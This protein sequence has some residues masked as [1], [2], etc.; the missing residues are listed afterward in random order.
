M[1]AGCVHET[2]KPEPVKPPLPPPPESRYEVVGGRGPEVVARLRA[3]PPPA[4]PDALDGR[5]LDSDEH[6][7][8]DQGLVQI[9]I[10]HFPAREPEHARERAIQQ[11]H[12]V[13]ADKVL[14]YPA[15]AKS[16][17]S[18]PELV[19]VYYV[20]LRLP[21]GAIFRDLSADERQQIGSDGVVISQVIGGTPASAANL[22]AGDF[23]L[24]L[25]RA[26]VHDK[27]MFQDLLQNHQG[28][29]VTLTIRRNNVTLDRL[30][31]LGSL[32]SETG[33]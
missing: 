23:V 20:H 29:R 9:G 28:R 16:G 21:F 5:A 17:A 33:H 15:P 26:P 32:A 2:N 24:K 1:L 4:R 22:R 25:D 12:D 3:A 31:R 18:E 10:G 8:G 7:W 11:G 30:V 27:T 13:G 19:A 6:Y 14:I